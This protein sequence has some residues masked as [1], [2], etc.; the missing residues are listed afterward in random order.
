MPANG[1]FLTDVVYEVSICDTYGDGWNGASLS[2]GSEDYTTYTYLDAYECLTTSFSLDG[3]GGCNVATADN[4]N[5]DADWDNGTCLF[6]AT[7]PSGLTVSGEDQPDDYPESIGF[8][9]SWDEVPNAERYVLAWWDETPQ[10]VPGDDCDYYGLSLI[11][12]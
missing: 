11:H 6:P 1:C 5:A 8:R 7:A 3:D 10:P 4:F 9:V 2:I 12:I